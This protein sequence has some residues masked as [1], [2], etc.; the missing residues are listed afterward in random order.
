MQMQI[1]P[2]RTDFERWISCVP[3]DGDLIFLSD[4]TS[5]VLPTC[6]SRILARDQVKAMGTSMWT[7]NFRSWYGY[8]LNRADH[9]I[10]FS[11][12]ELAELD[13]STR[14]ELADE[15]IRLG[16]PSIA[17]GRWITSEAWSRLSLDEKI[18]TMR[19]W[20]EQN[21]IEEYGS[22]DFDELPVEVKAEL[23]RI[24]CDRLLNRFASISGPNCFATVAAALAT[25]DRD[26][27]RNCWMHWP[28]FEQH[29]RQHGLEPISSLVPQVG[30]VLVIESSGNPIHAGYFLGT[31]L[32]FEKPGQDFYEPYRVEMFHDWQ[33]SWPETTLS[34]W[35]KKL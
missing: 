14:R 26:V 22:I 19:L 12:N 16:V 8:A 30:D 15:Q 31:G 32:Y 34:V 28:E 11:K 24:D 35:R 23:V 4:K 2:E 3:H 18:D 21:E 29:L 7:L 6:R 27:V 10:W 1:K 20:A 9:C 17:D 25:V 5:T 13:E 33:K